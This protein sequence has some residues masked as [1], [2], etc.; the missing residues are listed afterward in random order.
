MVSESDCRWL[1]W[2]TTDCTMEHKTR[3]MRSKLYKQ[4]N[5]LDFVNAF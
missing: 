3:G 4:Q 1:G 2:C 5:Q